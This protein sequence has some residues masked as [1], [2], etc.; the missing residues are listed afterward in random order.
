V[1]SPR[2]TWPRSTSGART[3]SSSTARPPRSASNDPRLFTIGA[4]NVVTLCPPR[5]VSKAGFDQ[6]AGQALPE[7]QGGGRWSGQ[8]PALIEQQ[9]EKK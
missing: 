4:G 1:C 8:L 9:L 2:A 3:R 5:T 6:V 7:G